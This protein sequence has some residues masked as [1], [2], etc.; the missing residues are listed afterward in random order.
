MSKRKAERAISLNDKAVIGV[1]AV[2]ALLGDVSEALDIAAHL[3]E[4]SERPADRVVS[5]VLEQVRFA[6][7]G[8]VRTLEGEPEEFE[9][10]T[11]DYPSASDAA[12]LVR[13]IAERSVR[14]CYI[15]RASTLVW[16]S[17]ALAH[18]ARQSE[19]RASALFEDPARES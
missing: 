2:A 8:A 18:H 14:S 7:Y 11:L 15:D 4:E 10:L 6:I 1:D 17:R 3:V 5:K 12:E 19:A 13:T 9:P 16:L